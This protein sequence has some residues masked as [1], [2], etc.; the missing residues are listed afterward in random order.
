MTGTDVRARLA[1]RQ[2]EVLDA[3]L[4][5]AVPPGFDPTGAATTTRVLLRKRSDAA[6]RAV[7]E[8]AQLPGWRDRF[9]AWAATCPAQG[10]GHDDADAFAAA[11]ATSSDA[12]E[13]EWARLAAVHAGTRHVALVQ[14]DGRRVLVV[15]VGRRTWRLTR[16]PAR[17]RHL[18]G[19]T[20]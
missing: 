6:V 11:L 8:L 9:H 7:P 15:G 14:L 17:R 3:L 20:A 10:C 13:R 16:R 2:Q 4:R 5:G 1:A 19:R 18:G 12:V